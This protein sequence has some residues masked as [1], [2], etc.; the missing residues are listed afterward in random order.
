MIP[1]VINLDKWLIH[2][3]YCNFPKLKIVIET[4]KSNYVYISE[5]FMLYSGLHI[6][7]ELYFVGRCFVAPPGRTPRVF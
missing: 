5:I 6:Q 1:N 2:W 3:I 7:Y 4:T